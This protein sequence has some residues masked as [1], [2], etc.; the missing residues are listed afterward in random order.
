MFTYKI[1]KNRIVY[2]H[3]TR[4]ACMIWWGS[5][6]IIIVQLSSIMGLP[7]NLDFVGI[8]KC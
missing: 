7:S 3:S 1:S 6:V 5:R 8:W 2:R 4:K